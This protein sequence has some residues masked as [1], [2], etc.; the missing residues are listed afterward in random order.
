MATSRTWH[1]DAPHHVRAIHPLDPQYP[2][3]L[4]LQQTHDLHAVETHKPSAAGDGEG[5]CVLRRGVL[6]GCVMREC[7]MRYMIRGQ[8]LHA[9]ETHKPN[10]AGD[11]EGRKG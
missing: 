2:R 6:R 11:G 8:D 5:V 9:V 3:D 1:N 10:A 7:V 4:L